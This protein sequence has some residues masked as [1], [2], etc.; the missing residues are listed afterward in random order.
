MYIPPDE[1]L[2]PPINLPPRPGLTPGASSESLMIFNVSIASEV[3]LLDG[4][5]WCLLNGITT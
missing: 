2:A 1:E 4:W 5:W 3:D